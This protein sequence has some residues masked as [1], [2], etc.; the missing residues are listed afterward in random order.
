VLGRILCTS[1]LL[2]AGCFSVRPDTPTAGIT[3]APR[4]VVN[5]AATP[6]VQPPASVTPVAFADSRAPSPDILQQGAM[7]RFAEVNS[8]CSRLRRRESTEGRPKPEELIL[9]KERKEPFSVHFKWIG[10]EA[11]GREVLYVK[12]RYEDKLHVLTA[13]GDVPFVPAGRRMSL[14]RDSMLVKI[15]N[16]NHDITDAGIGFNLRDVGTL[17]AAS[18]NPS[19]GVS[20]KTL[21]MVQRSEYPQPMAAVE[22]VLPPGRDPDLPRGG[23]RHIFYCPACK[24]P[25]LYLCFDELGRE[26]NYNCYDRIQ[27]D[28]K[29]DEDDFNPDKVWGKKVEP[30]TAK[31]PE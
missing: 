17:L 28:L 8:Y 22:I 30:A 25:L 2:T 11:Q 29:L 4:R 20:A 6:V 3:L 13:A 18:K 5:D 27:L 9:F 7:Q 16:P 14:A 31:K 10:P 15:A 19:S 1:L 21:G 23:K 12:G 26:Q 24:L